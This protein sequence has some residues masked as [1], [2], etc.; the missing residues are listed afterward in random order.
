ML[1]DADI[2]TRIWKQPRLVFTYLSEFEYDRYTYVFLFIA[3]AT[4]SLELAIANDLNKGM[5][6]SFIIVIS[7]IAGGIFWTLI[8]YTFAAL[9]CRIG[10]WFGGQATTISIV[11]V[12]AYGMLP[13]IMASL[14]T[15]LKI[16]LFDIDLFREDFSVRNYAPGLSAFYVISSLSQLALAV[17]SIYL[18][19]IGT[20]QL[21]QMPIGVAILNL[22][23]PALILAVALAIIVVPFL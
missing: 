23:L 12:M 5:T 8:F 11:R 6:F 18:I 13:I 3:A 21:Q 14:F 1:T 7:I 17:S 15:I 2:F 4:T 9:A 10:E 16:V 22:I 20:S 19:V